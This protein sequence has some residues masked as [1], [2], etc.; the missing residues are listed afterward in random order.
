M[1]RTPL[2]AKV[3]VASGKAE[4]HPASGTVGV[5]MY[6]QDR[7]LGRWVG[8]GAGSATSDA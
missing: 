2:L 5:W 1:W 8:V 7:R 6:E 3:V 4:R